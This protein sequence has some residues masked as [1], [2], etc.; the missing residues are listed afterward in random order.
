VADSWYHRIMRWTEGV[1]EGSIIVGK[2]GYG[3]QSNQLHLPTGISFDREGNLY[4]VDRNN[5]RVQKFVVDSN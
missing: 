5:H 4:V 3:K 2:N 1:K